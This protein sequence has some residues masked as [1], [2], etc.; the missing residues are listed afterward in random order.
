MMRKGLLFDQEYCVGCQSCCVACR[1]EN[2]YDAETWGI[3]II[4]QTY[5]HINGRVQ[6]DFLPFPTELCTLCASRIASG[7]DTKPSCVKHCPTFCIAYGNADDLL[8]M[9]KTMKRPVLY[10]QKGK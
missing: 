3:K 2:D 4:E 5:K 6:V 7:F 9:S 10:L 8:E 1:Q